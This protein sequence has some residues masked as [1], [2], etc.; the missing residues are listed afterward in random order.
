MED[1]RLIVNHVWTVNSR[2]V[3]DFN[4]SY[5]RFS[6]FFPLSGIAQSYP[7]L[8]ILDLGGFIIGPNSSL[9][10]SRVFNEYLLGDAVTWTGGRYTVKWGGQYYWF[11]APSDFLQEQRG[12]YGYNTLNQLV[13]DQVPNF[14]GFSLQGV[15]NGFFS[16]NSKNFNLFVQDDIKVNRRLTLNVGLRYDFFG[17]PAGA[18][19]NAL[20]S[21]ASLPGTPLVFNV[22]KQDWNNVGPR[23]GFAW[24]PTG[25]GTWAVR[26][27]AG[28]VY[29]E[30]P[31][32]FYSNAVPVELQAILTPSSACLGIFGAVPAWCATGSGFLANGAMN[33]NFVP[34]TTVATTRAL[35]TQMM[36]DAKDPKVFSWS[37][38]VQRELSRNTSLDVRYL[39]SR[40][41]ELPVQLELNSMTPF[42]VGAQPLPT[43]IQAS[44]I[45]ITVPA[46]APTLAQFQSLEGLRYAAQGFTGGFA[47]EAAPVELEHL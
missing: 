35:T 19:L 16:G 7:T 45:P 10:Q 3:N 37:L 8:G 47:T 21:I 39:G 5:A 31:W 20:N 6:Q 46:T 44:A 22:P 24:D 11:I 28:V 12:Q 13:N 43:Y 38:D 32:G 25:A 26:G 2:L 29:D 1:A 23:L 27:G 17:N 41:L 30:I 33:V 18:K 40:A 9:P 42:D 4:A 36:A 14:P 34:P 15:G